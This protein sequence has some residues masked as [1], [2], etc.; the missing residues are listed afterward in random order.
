VQKAKPKKVLLTQIKFVEEFNCKVKQ[1]RFN[2]LR[3][4]ERGFTM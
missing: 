1:K 3:N 4:K 2:I